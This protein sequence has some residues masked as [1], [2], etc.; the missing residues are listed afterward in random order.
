M[1]IELQ[2]LTYF[3]AVATSGSYVLAAERLH[4]SQPALWRKVKSLQGELGVPLFERSG[5]RVVLTSAGTLLLAEAQ[6]VLSAN[7][8]LCEIA[9]DLSQGRTGL[10][11]FGCFPVHIRYLLAPVIGAFLAEHPT[12]RM[13]FTGLADSRRAE[14]ARRLYEDLRLGA[15]DLAMAPGPRDDFDGFKA[16]RADIVAVLPENHP[17]HGTAEVELAALRG[18]PLLA[19]PLGYF[20]RVELERGAAKCGFSPHVLVESSSPLSLLALGRGGVGIPIVA[21]DNIDP[22]EADRGSVLVA[23]DGAIYTD[24]WLH[25]KPDSLSSAARNFAEM[26]RAASLGREK[27]PSEEKFTEEGNQ[28]HSGGENRQLSDEE[29]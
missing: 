6:R 5:N 25:W 23:S 3:T 22:S 20:S 4:V 24:V 16:Y 18:F 21:R 11:R 28:Q 15:L 1:T 2:Q 13:E 8:R 9:A 17:D 14:V 7:G 10:V 12:I 29:N 26:I 27:S 19:A